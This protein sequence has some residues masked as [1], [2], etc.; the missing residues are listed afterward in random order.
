MWR[1]A[2]PQMFQVGMLRTALDAPGMLAQ[3][4][5][6]ASAIEA[7]GQAPRLV[8]GPASNIKITTPPD[9]ALARAILAAR[10]E[11]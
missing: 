1:A 6:E 8:E 4:T 3:A 2:T 10:G 9:L 7:L 11:T 5:D